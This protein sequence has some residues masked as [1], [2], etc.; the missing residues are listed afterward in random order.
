MMLIRIPGFTAEN[1]LHPSLGSYNS[2]AISAS[3]ERSG[4]VR[5]SW[6]DPSL[7]ERGYIHFCDEEERR[8]TTLLEV[9]GVGNLKTSCKAGAGC[10]QEWL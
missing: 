3:L 7:L 10:E 4:E 8:C 5:A 2:G 6:Y 1:S 9:P